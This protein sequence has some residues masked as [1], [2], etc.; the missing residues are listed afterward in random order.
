MTFGPRP[1]APPGR[2]VGVVKRDIEASTTLAVAYGQVSRVMAENPGDVVADRVSPEDR[3]ARRFLTELGVDL[4]AGG[5]VR[6]A[7]EVE[8]GTPQVS[9]EATTVPLGWQADGRARLFPV[10][11]GCL[12]AVPA[13]DSVPAHDAA[14][15]LTV[16]GTYVVPLGSVGRFGDGLIGRRLA[17]QSLTAFLEDA[18]ARIDAKVH[19]RLAS[20]AWRPAPYPVALRESTVDLPAD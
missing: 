12:R 16:A 18:A 17:R 19:R 8:I 4:G 15:T 6:Q 5:A 9:P 14:T 10:F 3:R 1:G 7:V 2:T 20:V 13:H 11:D